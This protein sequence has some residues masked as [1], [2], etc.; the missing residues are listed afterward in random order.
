MSEKRKNWMIRFLI[1]LFSKIYYHYDDNEFSKKKW[2]ILQ[3]C[4]YE[5]DKNVLLISL[6]YTNVVL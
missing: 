4:I 6:A 3:L 5:N 2:K 1:M